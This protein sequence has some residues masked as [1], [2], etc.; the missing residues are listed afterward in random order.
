MRRAITYWCLK[1]TN[2]HPAVL[3][4]RENWTGAMVLEA[5]SAPYMDSV[6]E[7]MHSRKA[8]EK[9]EAMKNKR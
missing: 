3:M 7:A 4:H 2:K 1:A 9:F 5:C 6:I 8:A